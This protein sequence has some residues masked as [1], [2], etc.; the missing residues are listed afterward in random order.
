MGGVY[1]VDSGS[2]C[3]SRRKQYL[4]CA[5]DRRSFVATDA[6]RARLVASLGAGRKNDCVFVV[7]QRRFAS[8]LAVDG[9]R[10]SETVDT[11]FDRR[12]HREMVAG[13]K[14]DCVHVGR[15]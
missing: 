6:E 12:G 5:D 11:S 4:D 1:R 13:W 2:R 7:A 10:R 8:L 15:V 9:W 3:E 14:D